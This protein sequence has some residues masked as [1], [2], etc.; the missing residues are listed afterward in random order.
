MLGVHFKEKA[1]GMKVS[2]YMF[3]ADD[4]Y[5][6]ASRKYIDQANQWFKL[7]ADES[8]VDSLY[9]YGI[10][11]ARL[12]GDDFLQQRQLG[13]R[14]VWQASDKNHS[15]ALAFI[16]DCNFWGSAL[17]D[18]DLEHARELYQRAATQSHPGAL[19]QLGT[20]HEKGLG[21]PVDL[22]AALQCYLQ[23]ADA[24]FPQAQFHLYVMHHQGQAFTDDRP[25]ALAWLN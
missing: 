4:G 22:N 21:G 20:M 3:R 13:E 8:H 5:G 14:Y 1:D 2:E 17:Y 7:A 12:Q 25:R 6:F 11:L 23:A 16:G 15:A 10:Y 9:E 19:A 24:G 18:Q